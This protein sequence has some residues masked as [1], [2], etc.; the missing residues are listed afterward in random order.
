MKVKIRLSPS[1]YRCKYNA[2]VTGRGVSFGTNYPAQVKEFLNLFEVIVPKSVTVMNEL[3]TEECS[4]KTKRSNE[5]FSLSA[6]AEA[7]SRTLS[8]PQ[9]R[10]LLCTSAI[11]VSATPSTSK[12]TTDKDLSTIES[13]EKQVKPNRSPLNQSEMF[14]SLFAG[15]GSGTMSS[16]ACAPL[17][18]IRTRMQ[19]MGDLTRTNNGNIATTATSKKRTA[20]ASDQ[21]SIIKTLQDIIRSD[22][23]KGCFRGLAPTLATV[24][25]FWGLYFPLYEHCKVDLNQ[26]YLAARQ[27]PYDPDERIRPVVHMSSA[28]VSGT[29]ADFF[30]NPMFVVRTRMQTE[31]LHYLNVPPEQ[32]KAHGIRDTVRLLYAEGGVPIFWR[33]FTASLLGLTHVGIQFPV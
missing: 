9:P 32:R 17:D 2:A 23:I 8:R 18:L 21:L 30:C 24:P 27:I 12:F 29:I 7:T 14:A 5:V 6:A 28:V 3:V 13:N 31:A 20:P 10:Q 33:G 22:G 4:F 11:K 19:V 15:A 1:E 25:M 16:I 26:R